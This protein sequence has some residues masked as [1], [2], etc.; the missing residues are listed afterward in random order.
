MVRLALGTVVRVIGYLL[1]RSVGEALDELA[2][3]LSVYTRPRQLF[4]ARKARRALTTADPATVRGLLAPWWVPYRHGLDFV[5]DLAAAATNQAQD[6]AER[7]RAAA[8]EQA[9]AEAAAAPS[10]SAAG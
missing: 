2:A 10:H 3:L 4:A 5:S 7:R 6:V 8:L 1:V 9:A